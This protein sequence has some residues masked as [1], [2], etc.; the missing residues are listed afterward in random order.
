[1][2]LNLLRWCAAGQHEDAFIILG[3]IPTAED[4]RFLQEHDVKLIVSCFQDCCTDRG[5]VIPRGAVQTKFNFTAQRF[6]DRH[7]DALK[8]I[9]KPTLAQGHGIYVHCAAGC[10]RAPVAAAMI[11]AC[12]QGK[13]F[14]DAINHIQKLRNIEPWKIAG[15]RRDQDLVAWV[16]TIANSRTLPDSVLRVPAEFISAAV[17]DSLWHMVPFAMWRQSDAHFKRGVTLAQSANEAIV[18]DRPYCNACYQFMPAHVLGELSESHVKWR[19][20]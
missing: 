3:G 10:H 13:C 8:V 7:W 5:G 18:H 15:Q 20:R 4:C 12:F 11:L 2:H 14:D 1:M 17:D 9:I 16:H 19:S 6:R